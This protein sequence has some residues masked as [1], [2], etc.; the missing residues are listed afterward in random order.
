M[1]PQSAAKTIT[2]S[3][4]VHNAFTKSR[5]AV[6]A[7]GSVPWVTSPVSCCE[8][9]PKGKTAKRTVHQI[10]TKTAHPTIPDI[11]DHP[12]YQPLDNVRSVR[13]A[14]GGVLTPAQLGITF[15]PLD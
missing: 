4:V 2:E 11:T 9:I 5:G 13:E 15:H 10:V 14:H 1:Y 3:T 7:P 8:R 6:G 12:R